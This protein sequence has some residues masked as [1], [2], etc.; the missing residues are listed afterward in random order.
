MCSLNFR[1]FFAFCLI[2]CYHHIKVVSS[3]R[4]GHYVGCYKENSGK[5]FE[6]LG[7]Y[8]SDFRH[9]FDDMTPKRCFQLCFRRG[10]K[11][12]GVQF[13][14][15]CYCTNK[16]LDKHK[17]TADGACQMP[18]PGDETKKC[19]GVMRLSVYATGLMAIE[20]L[21]HGFHLGCFKE[22]S[23]KEF[24]T[25]GRF[26]SDFR[27]D[28]DTLTPQLCMEVC[29]RAGFKLSGVQFKRECYCSDKALDLTKQTDEGTCDLPCSGNANQRCGGVLRLDVFATGWT[30]I[31][32]LPRG[33]HLGCFKENSDAISD[34]MRIF[35][36]YRQD[37]DNLTPKLCTDVCSRNGFAYAGV[38][39]GKE[40]Y[41]SSMPVDMTKQ[42][43]E[44]TCN[45]PC[46]GDASQRCGG[47]LRLNVYATG[48][49]QG[50][51]E[52]SP[53]SGSHLGCFKENSGREFETLG[54]YFPDF[55]R[56]F[57][58]LTPKRCFELCF[59]RGFKFAGLQFGVECYCTNKELDEHRKTV[60]SACQIPCPGD[61][62][63]KCGG[64]LRLNVYAT[65]LTA[66]DSLPSGFH[67]GCFKENS[68]H[69]F[70]TKGRF[71]PDFRQDSDHLTPKLCLKICFENGYKLSG[72]QFG[73][74]CYCSNKK[75][76]ITK[77]TDE[78]SCK[79]GCTGDSKQK[80]G[81]VMR[82]N[83]YATG[84][85]S[86][87]SL[88]N[89]F[90]LG[91]FRETEGHDVQ[92]SERIFPDFRED[93][94]HL[95]PKL[96][97]RLCAK[98]QFRLAG[99][100]FGKECYCSNRELDMSRQT[101]PDECKMT[102]SGDVSEKCGGVW[103]MNV[104]A[105]GVSE[106]G[107][108][109]HVQDK[110]DSPT[111]QT[112]PTTSS[113]CVP[114]RTM[115]TNEKGPR[116]HKPACKNSVILFDDFEKIDL[117]RWQ[118]DVKIPSK[119]DYEFS[120]YDSKP[121]NIFIKHGALHI[122]PTLLNESFVENG[123]LELERCTGDMFNDECTRGTEFFILPPV[124]SARITTKQKF[125]FQ[126]G[127]IEIQAKFPSGDWIA[128]DIRLIPVTYSYGPF[129]ESGTIRILSRGNS[130]LKTED[131]REIGGRTVE[132]SAMLGYGAKV[133]SKSVYYNDRSEWHQGFHNFTI[134]WTPDDIMFMVDGKQRQNMMSNAPG[135]KLS[136]AV[137]FPSSEIKLWNTGTSIAPFDR[138]FHVS[139]G[140]SVG[141]IRDFEDGCDNNGKPKPWSN[142][143][144]RAMTS[145]W[146]NRQEW[147]TTWRKEDSAFIVKSIKI[148]AV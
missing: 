36:E 79:M 18:C 94:D 61:A 25:K 38:Q 9:D 13:G 147:Q 139:L 39:F 52:E 80:C 136:D 56:D 26:F 82:L 134:L 84:V 78:D 142:S 121:E 117:D 35:P 146:N 124:Q 144:P 16:E 91:C 132:A 88:P 40:C 74:E 33:F 135:L 15:E 12:A 34:A 131:G 41:C 45:M 65:G 106:A 44:K 8:F 102:C 123:K 95:T 85:S 55:R 32:S 30:A 68:G 87:N 92:N 127:L 48:H 96:C 101:K 62:A 54:R 125:S 115:I 43:D 110:V 21:P 119:P 97:L 77:Q 57:D 83:V 5:D 72:V 17:K 6:T 20:S 93:F 37:L 69:E 2:L 59:R 29:F 4:S 113:S 10:F 64:K 103:R 107:G 11:Y 86:I 128:A 53:P 109:N 1:Q 58:D 70:D 63:E 105:T 122:Q 116:R 76:D 27:Q 99:V 145:F 141:G 14:R 111:Q 130:N 46:A 3:S 24:E 75:L 81:G 31:D 47:T 89:G 19:G 71:F 42:T 49:K 126:Y 120:V 108:E 73:R 51:A 90:H 50:K 22:N 118:Y 129:Y 98:K 7:R 28:F 100:Q 67:L 133:R 66:I 138:P 143:D 23:G 104:Y 60:D 112:M 140:V 148:T 137:G 114:A